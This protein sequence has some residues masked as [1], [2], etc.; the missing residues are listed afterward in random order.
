MWLKSSQHIFI[1]PKTKIGGPGPPLASVP[2][3]LVQ[4]IPNSWVCPLYVPDRHED[5]LLIGVVV[6]SC[7]IGVIKTERESPN[8]F[9]NNPVSVDWGSLVLEIPISTLGH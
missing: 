4:S 5:F 7:R 1:V 3:T 8:L 9:V 6:N 2:T